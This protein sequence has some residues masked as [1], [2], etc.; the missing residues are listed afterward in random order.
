MDPNF[1]EIVEGKLYLATQRGLES[2]K[3][4]KRFNIQSVISCDPELLVG[5]AIIGSADLPSRALEVLKTLP[6]PIAILEEIYED[7]K[8]STPD[9]PL[10]VAMLWLVQH[11]RV[12]PSTAL[13]H[14]ISLTTYPQDTLRRYK[15]LA[16]VA[17][18]WPQMPYAHNVRL[19]MIDDIEED[20]SDETETETGS[21]SGSGSGSE[22]TE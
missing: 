17:R 4:L 1:T 21:E 20:L 15:E 13:A 2:R 5:N 19:L 6:T 12:D 11:M 3:R 18:I 9:V 8:T 7:T 14:I 10:A 22:E 16:A